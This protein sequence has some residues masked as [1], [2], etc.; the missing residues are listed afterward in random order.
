MKSAVM[1][2]F[3]GAAVDQWVEW[4]SFNREVAGLIP[5]PST[6]LSVDLEH[7]AEP[8]TGLVLLEV[9]WQESDVQFGSLSLKADKCP[10]VT[11][12]ATAAAV[13][14]AAAA[15]AP[16]VYFGLYCSIIWAVYQET[17]RVIELRKYT[18]SL[19]LSVWNKRKESP[20]ASALMPR[21][22]NR[23]CRRCCCCHYRGAAVSEP[24]ACP[25]GVTEECE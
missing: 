25:R 11:T 14:A 7:D 6:R 9:L 23:K 2:Q 13:R 8:Q 20:S 24:L 16:W 5:N 21:L 22:N 19:F 12:V 15:A 18:S 10:L 17:G 4:L 1:F 3:I